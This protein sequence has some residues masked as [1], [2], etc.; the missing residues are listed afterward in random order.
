MHLLDHT[1]KCI[2]LPYKQTHDEIMPPD[3]LPSCFDEQWDALPSCFDK[4]F[5]DNVG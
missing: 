2:A 1:F 5:Y 3:A 4:I